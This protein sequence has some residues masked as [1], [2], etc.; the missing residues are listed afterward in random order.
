MS[1]IS[2]KCP[3]CDGE[4][5]FD[6]GTQKYKC[7]Y[8]NST[9]SQEEL[10][11]MM[12]RRENAGK[13]QENGGGEKQAV[14]YS[15]P[16]CGAQVITDETTAATFCFYC[17]NPVIL[18]GRLE[19]DVSPDAVI[20]FEIDRKK[21]EETFLSYIKKKWF[22]PRGFFGKKN[23]QKMTGVYFP[24]WL[25]GAKLEGSVDGEA[26]KIRIWRSG[27]TEYTQTSIYQVIRQG[28]AKLR[29]LPKRALK[30]ADL[31]LS[32]GVLP[33]DFD[34]MKD[35]QMGYLSGFFAEKRDMESQDLQEQVR[36]GMRESAQNLF[37]ETVTGYDS[38]HLRHADFTVSEESWKYVLLPVWTLTYK[39][40]DQKIYYF[41]MNG[42]NGKIC[43]KLPVD[44]KRL[45]GAAAV[46]FLAVLLVFLIG[47]ALT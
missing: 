26:K 31:D 41:S 21:A 20:P 17:H 6:P 1:V 39:G 12:P 15:C 46:V 30:K 22:V 45:L 14:V 29:N 9:F 10:N 25:Y 37:R 24:Y 13:K 23:L 7:E 38:V 35:F 42:Q 32:E 3:N 40:R 5:L 28:S 2:L 11:D 16:S 33:Y 8:C 18:E 19:G 4:L 44:W 43:G 34:H 47:G 36:A 27:D